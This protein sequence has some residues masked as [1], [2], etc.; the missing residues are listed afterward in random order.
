[1]KRYW[2]TYVDSLLISFSISVPEGG[3]VM[4][5]DRTGGQMVFIGVG[6]DEWSECFIMW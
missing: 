4:V 6:H 5:D 3:T 1:M 2:K